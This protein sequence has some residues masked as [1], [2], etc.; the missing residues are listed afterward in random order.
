[1]KF[2]LLVED[3]DLLREIVSDAL[4]LSNVG[5]VVHAVSS[6]AEA[7]EL[8]GQQTFDLIVTDLC[9]PEVDGLALLSCLRERRSNTPVIVITAHDARDLEH[10][11]RSLGARVFLEKPFDLHILLATVERLLQDPVTRDAPAENRINGFTLQSFLQIMELDGKTSLVR[12]LSPDEHEGQL[13]FLNGTLVSALTQS[14]TGEDAVLEILSWPDPEIRISNIVEPL[15]PNVRASL[16][17]L[18][19]RSCQNQ[20]ELQENASVR[21]TSLEVVR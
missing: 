3:D 7:L 9:M 16:A 20:D 15:V 12:V 13:R 18:L 10:L 8:I 17:S 1:M 11:V 2:I 14:V 6:G 21:A 4:R 19:L 5:N